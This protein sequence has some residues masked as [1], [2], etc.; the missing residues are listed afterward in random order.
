MKTP[1]PLKLI[2]AILGL[3][4]LF[5]LANL[6]LGIP[7]PKGSFA[8]GLLSNLLIVSF[9]YLLIKKTTLSG[10]KLMGYLFCI[11]FI[12]GHFNILIE[13]YIFNVTDQAQSLREMLRGLIFFPYMWET[14]FL[15]LRF[16]IAIVF[17]KFRNLKVSNYF[18]MAEKR[19]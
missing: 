10:Y 13:A 8:G 19:G 3:S 7:F 17:K 4:L 1:N 2:T 9:F 15:Y 14:A 12:I 5:Y 6:L 18:L 11:Y 16:I